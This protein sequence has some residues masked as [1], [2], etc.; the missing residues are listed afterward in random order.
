MKCVQIS[1]S[2]RRSC[3]KC[4]LAKTNGLTLNAKAICYCIFYNKELKQIVAK[5]LYPIGLID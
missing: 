1:L 4:V 5:K 2:G 3:K